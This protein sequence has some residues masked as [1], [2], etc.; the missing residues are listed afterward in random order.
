M[1]AGPPLKA[2]FGAGF[3]Y[4]AEALMYPFSYAIEDYSFQHKM[5]TVSIIIAE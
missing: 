5:Y 1:A 3:N 4:T 2:T